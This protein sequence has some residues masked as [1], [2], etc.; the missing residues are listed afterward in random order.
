MFSKN[1]LLFLPTDSS[2]LCTISGAFEQ[3]VIV[4]LMEDDFK[5]AQSFL[6]KMMGAAKINL[7]QDTLMIQINHQNKVNIAAELKKRRPEQVLVFGIL[8]DQLC[9]NIVALPYAPVYFLETKF[10]FADRLS[11]LEPDKN[12]K[13]KLWS[14]MQVVF[15]LK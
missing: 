7:L 10:L 15:N 14:A 4:V 2:D 3:K 13:T 9:L 6:E 5:A 12:L 1:D 11:A 8:P